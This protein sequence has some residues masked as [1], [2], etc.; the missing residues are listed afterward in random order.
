M[1]VLKAKDIDLRVSVKAEQ[2]YLK[3]DANYF[4]INLKLLENKLIQSLTDFG[5]KLL[6]CDLLGFS[7]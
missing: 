5:N 4:Y 6:K 7:S 2:K 1:G 3:R